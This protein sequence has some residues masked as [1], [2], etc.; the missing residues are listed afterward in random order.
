MAGYEK[1]PERSIEEIE[2]FDPLLFGTRWQ[3][4]SCY[5]DLTDGSYK[6]L[7]IE[8][9]FFE[10]KT[11]FSCGLDYSREK[12]NLKFYNLGNLVLEMPS[13]KDEVSIYFQKAIYVKNNRVLRGGV[14]FWSRQNFYDTPYF[15]KKS[16]YFIGKQEN[17]RYRGLVF[18]LGYY[19][20]KF[21]TFENIKATRKAEDY[22]LGFEINSHIGFFSKQF[23]S[24]SSAKYIDFEATKGFLLS[25]DLLLISEVRAEGRREKSQNKNLMMNFK[26]DYYNLKYRNQTLAASFESFLGSK[27]DVENYVY[28]GGADGLRGYT[29][30]FKIGEK[31]WMFSAEDRIVTDKSL[32][33]ILQLGYVAY[34]DSGVI[35]LINEKNWSR[36]YVNVGFGLRMG[37]LKSAFGHLIYI[38]IAVPLVKEKGVDSYQFVIGNFIR[39]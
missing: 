24:K 33:G 36:T 7:K 19:E 35:R 5:Q 37:N 8:Y 32:W 11:P 26:F 28:L 25:E 15:L 30:H 20:D 6:K 16:L 1:N 17:R 18:Y 9:P 13:I 3:L 2:Y 39:F 23:G 31:R 4:F 14:E 27:L 12:L 34:F 10:L 21:K 22:N 29:N 38:S